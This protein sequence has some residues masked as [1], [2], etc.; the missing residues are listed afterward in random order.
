MS[1]FHI[2]GFLTVLMKTQFATIM[3]TSLKLDK[4]ANMNKA[5]NKAKLLYVLMVLLLY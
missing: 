5:V 2:N 1:N 3:G 4:I